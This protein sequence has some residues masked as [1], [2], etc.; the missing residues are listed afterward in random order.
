VTSPERPY[1]RVASRCATALP[2]AAIASILGLAACGMPAPLTPRVVHGIDDSPLRGA[3]T[4]E[5]V[6]ERGGVALEATA[7]LVP[8]PA[9]SF[10]ILGVPLG[11]G[12]DLRVEARAAAVPLARGRSFPFDYSSAAQMPSSPDVFIG[13]LGRFARTLET[14]TE[15]VAIAP[16]RDG[17]LVASRDGRV[18]AYLAH[19]AADG[20]ATLVERALLAEHAHASFVAI[21]SPDGSATLLAYGGARDAVTWLDGEGATRA[22]LPPRSDGP[23]DGVALAAA[24]DGTWVLAVGGRDA[25]G[26]PLATIERIDLGTAMT[27]VSLPPM[28]EGR[29]GATASTLEVEVGGSV[30][31]VVLVAGGGAPS[32]FVLIDPIEGTVRSVS[33]EPALDARALVAVEN[34]LVVAAGGVDTLGVVS[35]AVD[36]YVVRPDRDPPIARVTPAPEPLFA[37]RSS[38]VPLRLGPG[39]ALFCSGLDDAGA[40]VRGAELVE[41]RLD[42]L[43]GDVVPTGALPVDA[44]ALAMARLADRSV[45]VVGPGLAAAYIPP[46][47]PE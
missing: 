39:L 9:V 20:S 31:E 43:P 42:A 47:G 34:G 12:L 6:V 19:G 26:A 37:A 30:R 40:P 41:V 1:E 14:S 24:S 2:R 11:T 33:I 13:S 35:D 25:G 3:D 4:L 16:G 36:L 21:P 7:T 44:R 5:I 45:V 18:F 8:L 29:A 27:R 32:S 22:T 17:A 15:L 10:E 46:R 23:I 28:P 38:A